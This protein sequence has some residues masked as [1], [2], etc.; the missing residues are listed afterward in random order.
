LL[1]TYDSAWK[2]GARF[3]VFAFNEF[4]MKRLDN[5]AGATMIEVVGLGVL[6]IPDQDAFVRTCINLGVVLILDEDKSPASDFVEMGQVRFGAEP[7]LIGCFPKRF[8]WRTGG[9]V[10]GS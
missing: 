8:G 2:K 10:A 3:S 4:D 9:K 6:W 5:F 7:G 1:C